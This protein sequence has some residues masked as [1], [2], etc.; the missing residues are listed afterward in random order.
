MIRL[1]HAPH[2]TF[3]KPRGLPPSYESWRVIG[4]I[5]HGVTLLFLGMQPR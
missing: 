4:L 1:I 5:F 3:N 2:G